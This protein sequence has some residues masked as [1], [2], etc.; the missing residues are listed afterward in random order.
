MY[1]NTPGL[2]LRETAYRDSSKILTI[3]TGTE[4]KLTVSARGARRKNS[5]LA[6]SAQLLVFSEMTLFSNKDRWTLTEARSIEQFYG[7]R[8]DVALL[9]LG[10]YF[11]EL[12]EA[13]SDEDSPNPD[14]LRLCLNSL[15]ALSEGVKRPE[16]VKPV[17]EL[18]ILA[19]AGL[20]PLL[21]H[22]AQC[23]NEEPELAY[24]DVSGGNI[25]CGSHVFN[26]GM[27]DRYTG[28]VTQT[29]SADITES[30]RNGNL[31]SGFS[32]ESQS[33]L[34]DVCGGNFVRLSRAALAAARYIISCDLR[35]IFSF[36]IAGA[37][38][39]ELSKAM[40]RYLLT[41]LD[42]SFR[43]LDFYKKIG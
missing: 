35:K 9:A 31:R 42:R 28:E 26:G 2:V 12:T 36:T 37:A 40:E 1:I 24:L 19:L 29:H 23:G 33:G 38:I 34:A 5:V 6:A 4:G 13:I 41:Q 11:A 17:F 15:F 22:C 3:L 39:Q 21:T 43:T 27:T 8:Q 20:A 16:L 18:R 25:Y 14:L 32:E 7:L 10:S 30:A